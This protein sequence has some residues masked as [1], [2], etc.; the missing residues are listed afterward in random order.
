MF[1]MDVIIYFTEKG[2]FYILKGV[3]HPFREE[4]L[5]SEAFKILKIIVLYILYDVIGIDLVFP[6]CKIIYIS[7]L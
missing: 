7:D 2:P 6:E 5:E 4:L 1:D 3:V